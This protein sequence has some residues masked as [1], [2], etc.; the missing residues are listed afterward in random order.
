MPCLETALPEAGCSGL[1]DFGCACDNIQQIT[2]SALECLTDGCDPDEIRQVQNAALEA[3]ANMDVTMTQTFTS[4][5]SSEATTTMMGTISDPTTTPSVSV[6]VS[7]TTDTSTVTTPGDTTT[8]PGGTSTTT[9]DSTET[10]TTGSPEETTG[11]G[12]DGGDSGVGKPLAGLG[13]AFIAAIA[14]L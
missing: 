9:E 5:P 7:T 1:S 6:S 11:D 12:G 4:V 3:C 13:L 14:A 8:T 2:A 10:E